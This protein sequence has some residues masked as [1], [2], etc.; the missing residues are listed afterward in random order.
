DYIIRNEFVEHL[1]DIVMRRTTLAIGGSLTMSD[2]K[3]I[4]VI[5]GRARN[6]GPQRMSD[7]LDAAVA[8]LSDRNLMLL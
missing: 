3:Q 5:A 1:A 7:E 6:W 2:L 4:A 8:Q